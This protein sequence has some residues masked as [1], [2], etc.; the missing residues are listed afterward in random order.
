MQRYTQAR[1]FKGRFSDGTNALALPVIV[2]IN[3]TGLSIQP[4]LAGE[5][6]ASFDRSSPPYP[7]SGSLWPWDALTSSSPLRSGESPLLGHRDYPDARLFIDD[8]AIVPLLI[9]H[10][11]SLSSR[12]HHQKIFW[13]LSAGVLGIVILITWLWTSNTSIAHIIARNLPQSVHDTLG[14]IIIV[15]LTKDRFCNEP[16]GR[17]AL[18][19]LVNRLAPETQ[20]RYKHRVIVAPIGMINAVTAPGGYIIIGKELLDFVESPDEVGGVLAHEMGHAAHLH[21]ETATVRAIGFNMFAEMIFGRDLLGQASSLLMQLHFSRQAEREADNHAIQL[22]KNAG[23][24][25][26]ALAVFFRRLQK[27][28]GEEDN[29]PGFLRTHPQTEA[30]IRRMEQAHIP[31]AHPL[32]SQA[33]WQALRQICKQK[34]KLSSWLRKEKIASR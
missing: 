4:D 19:Q 34:G 22:M 33:Q 32:L 5:R 3:D 7:I 21:P 20:A 18:H 6:H 15:S 26:A 30:R 17:A 8:P 23:A 2:H 14:G 10:A 27:K 11:P 9:Q 31:N 24:D 16:E 13:W 1:A 12:A 28:H 29:M 25:P